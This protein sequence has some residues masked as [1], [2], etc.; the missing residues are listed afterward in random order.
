MDARRPGGRRHAFPGRGRAAD[1][2]LRLRSAAGGRAGAAADPGRL[3]E[4]SRERSTHIQQLDR[5]GITALRQGATVSSARRGP[6]GDDLDALA[7][8]LSFKAQAETEGARRRPTGTRTRPRGTSSSASA[9]A[10]VVLALALGLVLSWSL[11]GPIQRTE[12]RLAQIAAGDFSGRLDVPNRD[13]LGSLAANV[14]RM[15]DEL[16]RRLRRARDR[17][18]GTRASSSRTCRTSCA[19]R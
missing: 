6:A 15:N 12:A 8:D 3:R 16:R 5:A 9:P 1:E 2:P 11:I 4:R 19:R 14:N 10:S 18:A 13:E 17:R 7:Q